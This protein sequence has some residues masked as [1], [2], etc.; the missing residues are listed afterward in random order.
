MKRNIPVQKGKRY[1]IAIERMGKN[2]EGI[3][4]IDNFTIFV[5]FALPKETVEIS[6]E[7][8]KKNYAIGKMK[9]ILVKSVDRVKPHCP[10]YYQCGGCQLEHLSYEAQLRLKEEQVR[11]IIEHL[12]KLPYPVPVLPVIGSEEPW[13]YRNKM[14]FPFGRNGQDVV[15][16]CYARGSHQIINT[17]TCY[18]QKEGNNRILQAV[19]KMAETFSLSAYDEKKYCGFLRHVVGRVNDAENEM[20]LALVTAERAFPQ[21]QA[22]VDFLRQELPELT[23]IVQNINSQRNNIIMGQENRLLWGKPYI[24]EK[25]QKLSFEIS[26]NAFFQ[27]NTKQAIKLYQVALDFAQPTERDIII[28]AYCGTGTITSFLAQSAAKVYGI[29]I[30]ASAVENARENARLNGLSPEFIVGDT[31]EVLPKMFSKGIRP[32]II[33]TDPPRSGS[34]RKVLEVFAAMQPEKIVYVSCDPA[35]LARDLAILNELGYRTLRVQ[36]VDLFS[37]TAHV[38][39]VA[40][41]SPGG[42]G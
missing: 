30:N 19:R 24:T 21:A 22:V 2:G 14:M 17:E 16:G 41:L 4:K 42:K 12:A 25:M 29:E 6:I 11:S 20:M 34:T 8:V 39:S 1:T 36:P 37:Q 7:T 40:L 26:A 15:L 18:I 38:E 5:P 32:S 27:V 23:S 9:H 33:V 35:S 28:D 31:A 3:G 13:Y 10:V